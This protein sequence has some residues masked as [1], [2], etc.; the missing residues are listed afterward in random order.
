[1]TI[2]LSTKTG[3]SGVGLFPNFPPKRIIN[4]TAPQS[5]LD[6]FAFDGDSIKL[7]IN[8]TTTAIEYRNAAGAILWSKNVTDIDVTA[9]MWFSFNLD[10]VDGLL[11]I[12][13]INDVTDTIYLS[14]INAAGVVTNIGNAVTTINLNTNDHGWGATSAQ[15][16]GASMFRATQGTG[17]YIVRT[18]NAVLTISSTTGSILSQQLYTNLV[19]GSL[20]AT[21]GGWLSINHNTNNTF[22]RIY[23]PS[24]YDSFTL[25][26]TIL[27]IP[28]HSGLPTSGTSTTLAG[29][30]TA[31][32]WRGEIV[33]QSSGGGSLLE[34]RV[35]DPA[36]F[37]AAADQLITNYRLSV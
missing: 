24:A 17:D 34:P 19:A 16:R 5:W 6:G 22:L 1:M 11:Y 35:Y 20:P 15:R 30:L 36:E 10:V 26:T 25:I 18:T 37:V 7:P 14:T 9:T 28:L 23:V 8:A 27:A 33:W 4:N 31:L 32:Q 2:K 21:G 3:G 29:E 12:L 13:T